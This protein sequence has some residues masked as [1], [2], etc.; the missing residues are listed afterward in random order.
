[1]LF[2]S[3]LGNQQEY[4]VCF[5]TD[6]LMYFKG[7]KVKLQYENCDS[8]STVQKAEYVCV[9]VSFSLPGNS[10]TH[11]HTHTHTTTLFLDKQYDVYT[12]Y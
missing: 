1:M 4:K 3:Q 7:K 2:L 5:Y 6:V 10:G 9:F 12:P 8:C 11:T